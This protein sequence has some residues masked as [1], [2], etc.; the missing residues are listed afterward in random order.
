[1]K[2][3]KFKRGTLDPIQ[4]A[5]MKPEE[6]ALLMEDTIYLNNRYQ[7]NVRPV[8]VEGWPD[9]IHLSIKRLDKQPIHDWRDLQRIKNEI[10]GPD[11]EAVEL[12]PHEERLIDTSNQFHLW[13]LAAPGIT[14][15]FGFHDAR[16]VVEGHNEGS[17]QR[18]PDNPP[19]DLLTTKQFD[20]R[21]DQLRTN[22]SDILNNG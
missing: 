18:A 20:K 5:K 19:D 16:A 17:V 11:H 4:L 8:S 7:V 2:W 14:F 9:M 12:Y 22:R 21:V 15:P 1:M 10:V 6:R 3:T 13:A